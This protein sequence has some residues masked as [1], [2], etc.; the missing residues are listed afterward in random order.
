MP[1]RDPVPREQ[2]LVRAV[3]AHDEQAWQTLYDESFDPLRRYVTWRCGGR[4]EPVEEILQETWL[5]AV[6]RIRHFDPHRGTFLD[7]L[8]GIAGNVH[9]NHLRRRQTRAGRVR[10]L[11]GHATDEPAAAPDDAQR[12]ASDRVATAL[13]ALPD[14]YEAVLR[15]KYLDQLSVAQIAEQRGQ[16]LK[17]IESLLT[18]ARRAFRELYKPT[19]S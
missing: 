4:A 19:E 15:A 10:S 1:P 13:A 16:P 7:W 12:E 5:T 18:R 11:D 3:V 17:T 2:L 9:R 14:H 6:R 8:R